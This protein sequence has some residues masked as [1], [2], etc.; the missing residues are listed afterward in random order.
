V[1]GAGATPATDGGKLKSGS[2]GGAFRAAEMAGAFAPG[3]LESHDR[4]QIDRRLPYRN[5][6]RAAVVIAADE[7][8]TNGGVEH[9]GDFAAEECGGRMDANESGKRD[10]WISCA[11]EKQK[12]LEGG[13]HEGAFV[14][15]PPVAG[16]VPS[17]FDFCKPMMI[18]Q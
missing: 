4:A 5:E 1:A 7:Q 15:V 8:Q 11:E 16:T 6:S 9:E 17:C 2:G 3:R 12:E 13:F 14:V 18:C 10:A